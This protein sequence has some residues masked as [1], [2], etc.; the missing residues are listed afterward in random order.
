MIDDASDSDVDLDALIEAAGKE[1][2]VLAALLAS[3]GVHQ[4]ND[5]HGNAC[6]MAKGALPYEALDDDSD[7]GVI[8]TLTSSGYQKWNAEKKKQ[9]TLPTVYPRSIV[10][11]YIA[12]K[13]VQAF[14]NLQYERQLD[15]PSHCV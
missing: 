12:V 7:G 9:E 8:E 3:D 2:A 14:F 13:N 15:K 1:N 11:Y 6:G 5:G 10:H 4:R